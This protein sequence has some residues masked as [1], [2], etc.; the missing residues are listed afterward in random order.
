MLYPAGESRP[1]FFAGLEWRRAVAKTP[2]SRIPPR[3]SGV[4]AGALSAPALGGVWAIRIPPRTFVSAS[5]ATES[6]A[7]SA[8]PLPGAFV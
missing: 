1:G 3:V 4:F 5:R 7:R 8:R 6:L 2:G